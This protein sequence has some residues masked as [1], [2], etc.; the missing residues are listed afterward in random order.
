MK[1]TISATIMF[2]LLFAAGCHVGATYRAFQCEQYG[3]FTSEDNTY[4]CR[5]VK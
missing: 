5:V 1:E 4:A 2:V 3:V